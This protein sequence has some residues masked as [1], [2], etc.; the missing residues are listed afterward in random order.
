MASADTIDSVVNSQ[1]YRHALTREFFIEPP[2]AERGMKLG[3][4]V[5]DAGLNA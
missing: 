3:V 2:A 5:V 1:P 4:D